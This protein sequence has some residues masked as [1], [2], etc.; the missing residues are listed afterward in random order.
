MLHDFIY[1]RRLRRI[2]E[3]IDEAWK[4]LWSH[5]VMYCEKETRVRLR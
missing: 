1:V 2:D 5:A 4:K 3:H